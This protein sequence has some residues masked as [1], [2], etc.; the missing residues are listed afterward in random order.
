[1]KE[2]STHGRLALP[3]L[4][5]VFFFWGFVAAANTILIPVFKKYFDLLQWQSQ[6]VD[7]AYYIAYSVGSLLYF[8]ITFR[9]GDPLSRIGYKKG[10]IL[11]LLTSALGTLLFIPAAGME[12]FGLF[13]TGLF[14]VALGFALQQ[15]VAN[16]YVIALG[17]P[18]T[19]AHRASL[20]QGINSF[21]T[22]LSPLLVG[23]AIFGDI[24]SDNGTALTLDAVKTPYLLLGG[25]FALFA[26]VLSVSGLPAV[27][28]ESPARGDLSILRERQVQFGMLAILLY[29]GVEVSIQSNLPELMRQPEFLGLE[30]SQTLHFISLYWGSL[31]IGRW[32]GALE[33]FPLRAGVR[34]AAQVIVPL[35]AYLVI[36]AV[37]YIKGSPLADLWS[38]FPMVILLI[39]A[40][41]IAGKS[42][43]RT[44]AIFGGAGTLLMLLGLFT[45]GKLAVYSFIAGGLFC[46]VMWPCIFAITIRGLGA[47][48]SQ[49]SSLLIMMIL[50]GAI[51][52]PLQGFLADV[53]GIHTSYFIAALCFA[54]LSWFGLIMQR[55]TPASTHD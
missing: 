4:I 39:I 21:G 22:M 12:S 29:V 17:E 9:F 1:M 37:N 38:Y 51:V 54:Y 31:M 19:G 20:A 36:I 35:L 50:G 43:E 3:L 15:I 52:P 23:Y 5:S 44:M 2:P 24:H 47:R 25:A 49:A 55:D 40:S 33:I 13:L 27:R 26:G 16:P 18:A 46:S 53:M 28:M 8:F 14:V 42:P 32:T 11:G 45:T 10:L 30:S 48:T 6:L 41:F 7:S 34:K